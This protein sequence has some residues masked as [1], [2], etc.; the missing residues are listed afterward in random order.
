MAIQILINGAKGK[1]GATTVLAI[2]NE[3]DMSLVAAT[4]R[5]DD[6]ALALKTHQPDVV[7][8]FTSADASW[9]NLQT[10]IGHGAKPV[11]GSSGLTLEQ[12]DQAK[13]LCKDKKLGGI[14]APNFSIG[15][16][17]MMR[18]AQDC[19][20]YLSDVEIIETHHP[21]KLDA[22]SGTAMKTAEMIADNRKT[23]TANDSRELIKGALGAKHCDIPIHS[24]R[25]P[26]TIANQSVI[27]GGP[28]QT[29]TITHNTLD[30][31]SFM[32]GVFLACRHVMA[33]TELTY[34]LANII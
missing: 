27:F 17:L 22:P 18:Y 5:E 24:L 8:D 14:I 29:L 4:D 20:K 25:L 34:G 30:R 10:I 32:P 3:A 7:I 26:G 23:K 21:A 9:Q 6:L 28:G 2:G 12:I 31:M 15:A 13:A 19:A 11:I 1:M 33:S 16:I